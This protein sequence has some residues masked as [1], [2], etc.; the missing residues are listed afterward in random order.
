[1]NSLWFIKPRQLFF[2]YNSMNKMLSFPYIMKM[3]GITGMS[4]WQMTPEGLMDIITKETST[5][6]GSL[7]LDGNETLPREGI[8]K[9]ARLFKSI[10][11]G[12]RV[13]VYCEGLIMGIRSEKFFDKPHF[14]IGEVTG[15]IET[16]PIKQGELPRKEWVRNYFLRHRYKTNWSKKLYLSELSEELE[17][18]VNIFMHLRESE[19][20]GRRIFRFVKYYELFG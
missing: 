3:E 10:R 5:N 11:V 1:M 15:N 14:M 19:F 12:D 4:F 17:E 18:P 2:S 9:D 20:Y 8:K 7:L 6:L 13:V 16:L